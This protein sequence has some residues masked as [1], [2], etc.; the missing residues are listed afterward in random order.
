[1]RAVRADVQPARAPTVDN[2]TDVGC[3]VQTTAEGNSG[4]T[5]LKRYPAELLSE[6]D[7][8]GTMPSNVKN[9]VSRW[10]VTR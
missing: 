10:S 8:D 4:M 5:T 6:D 7:D 2:L 1:M 9:Y 3:S